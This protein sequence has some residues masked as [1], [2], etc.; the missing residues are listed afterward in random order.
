MATHAAALGPGGR[1]ARRLAH[2]PGRGDRHPADRR[3]SGASRGSR[4]SRWPRSSPTPSTPCSRTPRSRRSSAGRTWSEA[5]SPGALWFRLGWSSRSE[6]SLEAR[7]RDHPPP[8]RSVMSEIILAAEVGRPIGS[9]ATRRLRREGKIPGVIYGHGIDPAAV[10]VDG[11][12]RCASPSTATPGTNQLLVARHRIGRRTSSWP[13]RC[14]ATPCAAPSSTSTSRSPAATRSS[15]PTCPSRSSA[16]PW[17][18][19]T[20]TAW[21]TSSCSASPSAPARGHPHRARGRHLRHGPR[22]HGAG[23]GPGA[24]AGVVTDIDPESAIALAHVGRGVAAEERGREGEG[25]VAP[26][27]RATR[28]PKPESSGWP[29]AARAQPSA[30]AR[31]ADLLVVGLGNPGAEFAGSV[32]NVGGDAVRLLAERHGGSLQGREGVAGPARRGHPRRRPAWRWP[33]RPPT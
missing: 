2:L 5:R 11:T 20:A 8:R 15:P 7:P 21:W 29:G 18:C 24:P 9:S 6:E 22:R 23:G 31:P 17:R 25:E 32:H 14:S 12:R 10:A 1:A 33:C 26:R 13:E 28:P 4:S 16:R 3:A 27:P 19:S 30:A